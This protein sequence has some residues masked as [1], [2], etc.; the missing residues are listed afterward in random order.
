MLFTVLGPFLLYANLSFYSRCLTTE[1]VVTN[2]TDDGEGGYVLQ[3]QFVNEKTGKQ[4]TVATSYDIRYGEIGNK[5]VVL[6]DPDT[7]NAR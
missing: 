6:Y 4:V 2:I 5:V 3:V 7:P 1:S